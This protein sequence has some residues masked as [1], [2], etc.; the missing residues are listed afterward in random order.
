MFLI[1]APLGALIKR[2]GLGAPFLISILFFILY[3]IVSMQG[4]KLAKQQYFSA[5]AGSWAANAVL[6]V[7]GLI[8]LRNARNDA[9]LFEG[10]FWKTLLK[11]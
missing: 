6:L 11:K 7:I 3:T 8:F 10:V 9:S 4:E 1:G 2:G 5:P